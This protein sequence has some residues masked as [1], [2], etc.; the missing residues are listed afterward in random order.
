MNEKLSS[1]EKNGTL[2]DLKGS[3]LC[4]KV[5]YQIKGT[6]RNIINCFCEQCRRTSGHYVAATRVSKADFELIGQSSL[7]W[8]ESS[9]D[10]FRGF[11]NQCGGNLF[12]N[13][14]ESNEISIMAGTLDHPTGLKTIDNILVDNASDYFEI[15]SIDV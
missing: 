13:E 14:V 5:K 15:P 11:C 6:A 8:F 4:S 3:C 7:S 9:P 2:I 12:W 10:V 1:T